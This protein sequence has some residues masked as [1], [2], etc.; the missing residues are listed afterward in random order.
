MSEP[1]VTR[2]KLNEYRQNGRNPNKAGQPRG[3]QAIERSIT[4]Y[5][6]G[7]SLVAGADDVLIAGNQTQ[8]G[9]LAAGVEDVIEIETDGSALVVVKRT[10]LHSDDPRARQ[11]AYADNRTHELSFQLDVSVL[12]DDLEQGLDLSPFYSE[13]ELG[14]LGALP[15]VPDAGSAGGVDETV[16]RNIAEVWQILV[17]CTGEQHQRELL[18]RL[19]SEGIECR[20]LIS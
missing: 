10:D 17:S 2:R 9:A 14:A 13:P 1:K 19:Q 16:P 20:A 12:K 3:K 6:A 18:E 5:G 15:A 8:Q 4:D 7:R 11:L